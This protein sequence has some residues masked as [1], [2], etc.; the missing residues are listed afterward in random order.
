MSKVEVYISEER[1]QKRVAELGE[2]ISKDYSSPDKKLLVVGILKGSVMFMTDLLKKITCPCVIDFMATSS[3]GS[4]TVSSGNVKILKDLDV[5]LGEYDVLIVEDI[6][7]RGYTLSKILDILKMRHPRSLKLCALLDKPEG[8]VVEGVDL[9]Y[10]GFEIQN[11]FVVGY[12]LDYAEYYRN[13]PY[14]G[15]L[16][17]DEE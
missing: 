14:I 4:S 1:L 6:L 8:R 2:Q 12:G 3:Y 11:Q 9:A 13:L 10:S 7:D 16:H 15:I 5:D 17:L